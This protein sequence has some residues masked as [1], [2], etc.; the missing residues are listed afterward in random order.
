MCTLPLFTEIADES[1]Q[2]TPPMS[3]EVHFPP[4]P[5][6]VIHLV[7]SSVLPL[8]SSSKTRCQELSRP[9]G[10]MGPG[11]CWVVAAAWRNSCFCCEDREISGWLM[12]RTRSSN[13][14]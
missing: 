4:L 1:K 9:D 7:E 8:N 12:R 6:F 2:A 11:A 10:K 5:A 14:S 13:I 3:T